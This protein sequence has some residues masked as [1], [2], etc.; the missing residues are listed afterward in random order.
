MLIFINRL[1]SGYVVTRET[2]RDRE[3]EKDGD[4]KVSYE[5]K[6]TLTSTKLTVALIRLDR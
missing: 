3:G 1:A 2:Q 4:R 5:Y 6:Y